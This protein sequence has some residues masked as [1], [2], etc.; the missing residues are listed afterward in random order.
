MATGS[1]LAIVGALLYVLK[2]NDLIPDDIPLIGKLDDVLILD[3][4]C[5]FIK[6]DIIKYKKWQE[7]RPIEVV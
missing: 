7:N 2:R 5:K 4:C 6:K 1:I 3:A